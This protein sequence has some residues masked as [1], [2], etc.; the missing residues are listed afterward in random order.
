MIVSAPSH[1]SDAA[2]RAELIYAQARSQI[3]VRL[4]RAALGNS[5][6]EADGPRRITASPLLSFTTL[7]DL[8]NPASPPI[9]APA[10][11]PA[12]VVAAPAPTWAVQVSAAV[13]PTASTQPQAAAGLGANSGYSAEIADA[14]QRTGIPAAALASIIDAE[15]AKNRQGVWQTGSRNARSSATGLGQFLSGTWKSEAQRAGTWLNDV[16]RRN[17][18]LGTGGA[19]RSEMQAPLLALRHDAQASINATADYARQS[20]DKLAAAGATI[21]TGVD[22]IAHAAY[23]GH[24]LG[25][26]DA[27]RFLKGGLDETRARLLLDAQI[28]NTA[29][30]RQRA[31]AGGA[32]A[33]HRGWLLNF[34]ARHV[35]ASRFTG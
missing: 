12:A 9:A 15:A 21:G 7:I 17:G 1:R 13:R 33:A 20:L 10:A 16:A 14:S 26:R 27:I 11:A 18:W 19:I 25:L 5:A 4:W 24:N 34:M 2:R 30:I 28:G 35:N 6:D 31:A 32:S 23:L 8:G 29:A 3:D 22:D